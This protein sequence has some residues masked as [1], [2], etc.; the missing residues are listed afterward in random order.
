MDDST[1]QIL[2]MLRDRIFELFPYG[3]Q[4]IWM[5]LNGG[6]Y[7]HMATIICYLLTYFEDI[8][9]STPLGDRRGVVYGNL[10]K[11]LG[12]RFEDRM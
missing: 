7:Y 4:K 2:K 8:L 12:F 3:L 10:T 11:Y 9:A 1:R 6:A 5:T